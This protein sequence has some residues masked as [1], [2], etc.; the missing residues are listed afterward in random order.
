M[1]DDK[2]AL[3]ELVE[4]QADHDLV[5]EMLTVLRPSESWTWRWRARRARPRAHECRCGKFSATDTATATGGSLERECDRVGEPLFGGQAK[6]VN[7]RVR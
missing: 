3:L 2:M 6:D 7:R 1:T 4:K 5:R